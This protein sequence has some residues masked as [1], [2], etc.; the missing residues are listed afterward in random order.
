[1]AKKDLKPI[2]IP[3]QRPIA[4]R[5]AW[6]MENT[7]VR[8]VKRIFNDTGDYIRNLLSFGLEDWL[9]DIEQ[10]LIEIME[11]FIDYVLSI[12]GLPQ[13]IRQPIVRARSGKHQ[14]GALVLLL[15]VPAC[16]AAIN[17][18][19]GSVFGE[20]LAN[21]TRALVRPTNVDPYTAISLY[22][23]GELNEDSFR[24]IL[25]THGIKRAQI[26]GLLAMTTA[27]GEDDELT[28]GYWRGL[29]SKDQV[30]TELA[31]RGYT[32]QYVELWFQVRELIP[33]PTDVISIATREGFDDSVARR[34]GYDDNYPSE[35]SDW[36]EKQG[37]SPYWT[38]RMW[39]AHWRLPSA[40]QGFD[41][42]HRGIIDMDELRLLL[43]ALDIPSYWRERLIQLSYR[44]ITRVD[45]RRMY[46]LGV[47]TVQELYQRHLDYGYSPEDA[48]LMTQWVVAEYGEE[49]RALTKA[50]ILSAY[51]DGTLNRND[52][53]EYLNALGYRSDDI[54]IL[55]ARQDLK[56]EE[57]Y[58]KQVVENT[59]LL[60]LEGEFSE[61]DVYSTLGQ[62]NPPAG[63]IENMLSL[64]RLEKRRRIKKP[65]T[66]QLRDIWLKGIID[67]NS[68]RD[69]LTKEGYPPVYVD[70]LID[71]WR[72]EN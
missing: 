3:E 52:A 30:S 5:I 17:Q 65:T 63:F 70:W 51:Y 55:L 35:L 32:P 69:E 67:D 19:I 49:T 44:T 41:M 62:I 16:M 13:Q 24:A 1:M 46:D 66:T 31:K 61:T 64:W 39:R 9:E 34:F 22:Q 38:R 45:I 59:R 4:G 42:L 58:E 21:L 37:L 57:D 2:R 72:K 25:R 28:Q 47:L 68:F 26:D 53:I 15:L 23:R 18:G 40:S 20:V 50:D 56:R 54:G 36:G 60:F 7:L 71:L 33:S 6:W 43:R 10:G 48:E 14:S 12:E 29:V 27:L 11:P 8:W